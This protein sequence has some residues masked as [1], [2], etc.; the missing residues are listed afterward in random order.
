M[1]ILKNRVLIEEN[2]ESVTSKGII[3]ASTVDFNTPR[4]EVAIE[5]G[6]DTK[7]VKKGDKVMYLPRDGFTFKRDDTNYRILSE[8]NII[9]IV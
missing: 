3:V 5:V 4:E 9:A 2:P 1:K 6:T 8:D 7:W